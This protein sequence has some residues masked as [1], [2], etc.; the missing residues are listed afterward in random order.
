MPYARHSMQNMSYLMPFASICASGICWSGDIWQTSSPNPQAHSF[1]PLQSDPTIS[2]LN[3]SARQ[4]R[5]LHSSLA[6]QGKKSNAIISGCG[7]N[8]Q[9]REIWSAFVFSVA[10]SWRSRCI[11]GDLFCRGQNT[12]WTRKVHSIPVPIWPPL[13]PLMGPAF[14]SL[15]WWSPWRK[16]SEHD[17]HSG[18]VHKNICK[19]TTKSFWVLD[20]CGPRSKC[21]SLFRIFFLAAGRV[22]SSAAARHAYVFKVQSMSEWLELWSLSL[23]EPSAKGRKRNRIKQKINTQNLLNKAII[24]YPRSYLSGSG[25]GPGF[26]GSKPFGYRIFRL[27]VLHIKVLKTLK[28]VQI[29]HKISHNISTNLSRPDFRFFF[30]FVSFP[31]A[32]PGLQRWYQA[33]IGWVL[34]YDL[35]TKEIQREHTWALVLYISRY[36]SEAHLLVAVASSLRKPER[37]FNAQSWDSMKCHEI[38]WKSQ[39]PTHWESCKM[40]QANH[41]LLC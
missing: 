30:G 25:G 32:L 39:R 6:L 4:E 23:W 35:C 15:Q 28:L 22:C 21:L 24:G 9:R 33:G 14:W 31:S 17:M 2:P 16:K 34:K 1:Q 13:E 7:T 27:R 5:E 10:S 11:L 8:K 19:K 29:D 36:Y 20:P 3:A 18:Q 12:G 37:K 41:E 26:S 40:L 38:P